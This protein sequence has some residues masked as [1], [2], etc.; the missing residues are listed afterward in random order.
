MDENQH[1]LLTQKNILIKTGLS[2]AV[3]LLIDNM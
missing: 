3:L 1:S 2:S